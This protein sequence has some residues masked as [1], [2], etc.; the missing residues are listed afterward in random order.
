LAQQ[1]GGAGRPHRFAEMEALSL[2]R[3]TDR[4]KERPLLFGFDPLGNDPDSDIAGKVDDGADRRRT[5]GILSGFADEGRR[6]RF[7]S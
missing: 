7:A 5:L 4:C 1:F 3:R 6:G 2:R